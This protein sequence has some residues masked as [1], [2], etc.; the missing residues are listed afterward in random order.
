MEIEMKPTE[1]ANGNRDLSR[2]CVHTITTKPWDIHTAISKYAESGI[3]G[4]SVWRDTLENKNLKDIASELNNAGVE[5]VSLVRGGFFT[6][7]NKIEREKAIDE[8]K[9]AL[10]EAA[11][12]GAPMVVLVCGAT[13]GQ[14][15]QTDLKQT[16]EGIA[17]TLDHAAS[18]GVKLAIEP[19]HPMYADIRSSV[20][21]LK[22]ANDL[23]DALQSKHV[24][25]AVDA[26]HVW[27]DPEFQKE[28][29]RCGQSGNLSAYHI[30]D[31]KVDMK[32]MLNDRGLMGE[33]V[34][35][36]KTMSKEVDDAGFTGFYEVEVFSKHWWGQDQ[37]AYLAKIIETYQATC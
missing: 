3:G 17:K 14:S 4:I 12:I 24:G 32:D 18:C 28:I 2:L 33:G 30:C 6:S 29:V 27:W 21:T 10:D 1:F 25:I 15:V 26:F 37:D 20:S 8:N 7:Q 16:Q 34:I 13:P 23:C 36:L 35:D 19:L 11:A 31:W 9:R 5:P 22:S